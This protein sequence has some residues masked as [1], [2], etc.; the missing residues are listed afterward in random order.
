MSLSFLYRLAVTFIT[1]LKKIDSQTKLVEKQLYHSMRNKEL[2][3]L[4][5]L[6]KSL[7]YF[8]NSLNANRA[9]VH[10]LTR[11]EE[12]K[13]SED[14][15]DLLEDTEIE[16]NQAIEMCTIYRDILGGMMDAFASI[17]SNNLNIVM[18]V[19]TVITI[20]L[21]IP[22]LVASFYGMNFAELPLADHQFGFI[23]TI[24]LSI[25]LSLIGT[26]IIWRMTSKIK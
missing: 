9:V 1:I 22:T 2:F 8:S 6:N 10:K 25:V 16:F 26:V 23:I 17:V 18:K 15:I 13:K 5:E 20:A 3:D 4:M 7:V 19:L 21:A 14:D 12:F 11:S 24:S